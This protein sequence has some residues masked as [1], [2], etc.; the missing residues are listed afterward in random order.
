MLNKAIGYFLNF[1]FVCVVLFI[2]FLFLILFYFLTLQYC[3]VL[4]YVKMNLKLGLN[5]WILGDMN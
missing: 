1:I 4:P 5:F 3:M 2:F